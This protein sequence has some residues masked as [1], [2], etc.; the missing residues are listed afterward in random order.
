MSS[1]PPRLP[2]CKSRVNLPRSTTAADGEAV[3][4]GH[5]EVGMT[6]DARHSRRRESLATGGRVRT[7]RS[8]LSGR[9]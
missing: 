4:A 2:G 8:R 7:R 1:C 9:R 5:R 6:E 3:E